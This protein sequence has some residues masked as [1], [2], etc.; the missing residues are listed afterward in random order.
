MLTKDMIV[1]NV[2]EE[3]NEATVRGSFVVS[4][5]KVA[6]LK[7]ELNHK[8]KESIDFHSALIKEDIIDFFYSEIRVEIAKLKYQMMGM[9]RAETISA[10]ETEKKFNKI[11]ERMS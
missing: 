9:F 5:V 6:S 11:L 1:I 8:R 4:V 10:K 3:L 2:T 7:P